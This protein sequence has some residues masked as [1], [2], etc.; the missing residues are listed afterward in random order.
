MIGRS[1]NLFMA[2]VLAA[3]SL[4]IGQQTDALRERKHGRYAKSYGGRHPAAA[5]LRGYA[6][7]AE[8][9]AHNA[10]VTAAKNAKLQAK[11]DRRAARAAWARGADRG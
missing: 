3:A 2:S 1:M 6:M 11:A 7:Q 8:I 10:K 5:P 9:D 4:A